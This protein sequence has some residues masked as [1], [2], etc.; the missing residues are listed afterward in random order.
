MVSLAPYPG[1]SNAH[2]I[3][4]LIVPLC[5][6]GILFAALVAIVSILPALAH[7]FVQHGATPANARFMAQMVVIAAGLANIVGAP[8][9]ALATRRFGKRRSLLAL[10]VLYTISGGVGVFEPGFAVLI[11]SRIV[12]GFAAGGIGA[13]SFALIADYYHGPL[14]F[15]LLGLSATT[16]MIIAVIAI[17]LCGWLADR[18]GW[19]SVFYVFF[20]FGLISLVI[21]WA[22]IIEP[23]QE[24]VPL[25]VRKISW[26]AALA[27][28]WPIYLILLILAL[29]QFSTVTQG[30]FLLNLFGVTKA[31]TQGAFGAIPIFAGMVAGLFFG[32]LHRRVSERWIMIAVSLFGGI[33]VAGLSA[34]HGLP[35]VAG[36]YVVIGLAAGLMVPASVAMVVGRA[37]PGTREASVGLILS[38]FGVAQFLNPVVARPFTAA[39]GLRG[40][41]AGI[42][43]IILVQTA[44]LVF[45]TFARNPPSPEYED[46]AE[47]LLYDRAS[48]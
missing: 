7:G 33:A 3:G 32:W 21:A 38:V 39:F 42:G 29:G 2:A 5:G 46:R 18:F 19:G 44:V 23:P 15:T 13:L 37:L 30:P 25:T 14:R 1:E 45:G 35:Q 12:L 22:F 16:Q 6:N 8:A 47:Q 40:A 43:A 34:T 31:A 17:V 4:R 41:F 48:S 10:L 11:A 26:S 36:L 20:F 28:V 24:T 27:P 9:V